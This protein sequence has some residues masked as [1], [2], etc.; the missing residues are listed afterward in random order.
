MSYLLFIL[1]IKNKQSIDKD[2]SKTVIS[3]NLVANFVLKNNLLFINTEVI[4][5]RQCN[6][7]V[8]KKEVFLLPQIC[9]G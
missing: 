3:R 9:N 4:T 2:Q 5:F 8:G 1:N 6:F 7:F